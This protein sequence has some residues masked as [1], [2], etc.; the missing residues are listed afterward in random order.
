MV[1]A[2][3]NDPKIKFKHSSAPQ[4]QQVSKICGESFE[5]RKIPESIQI[6]APGKA[7]A[8]GAKD[9]ADASTKPKETEAGPKKE[10][11]DAGA[12]DKAD[13]PIT[14]EAGPEQKPKDSSA[15]AEKPMDEGAD[16]EKP[17][18]GLTPPTTP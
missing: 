8:G 17:K 10:S 18:D 6:A 7:E 14:A 2:I 13:A 11:K 9:K 3:N 16:A 5:D 4:M 1:E 15:P 12:K